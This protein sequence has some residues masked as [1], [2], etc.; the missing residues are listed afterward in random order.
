MN[1][2]TESAAQSS[3]QGKVQHLGYSASFPLIINSDG[4]PTYFMTL[5]D[6]EGLIKQY[7]M[8]S[9]Q[10]YSVVGVGE[11]IRLAYDNYRQTMRNTSGNNSD[12]NLQNQQEYT[13]A[14]SVL[15]IASQ[16][17]SDQLVY[18]VLLEDYPSKIFTVSQQLSKELALTMAGDRVT[19]TYFGDI[20]GQPIVE[21]IA[22][23]NLEFSQK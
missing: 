6:R 17:E 18:Y 5:K 22:F 16:L 12:F 23:D 19:V 4:I 20:A 11:T 7:A 13:V 8:V 9:V 1:G 21:A 14:G 2:A 3:A 10:N 15:R